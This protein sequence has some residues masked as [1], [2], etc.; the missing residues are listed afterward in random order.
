MELEVSDSNTLGIARKREE[1][2]RS[3]DV[4]SL[5]SQDIK[6]HVVSYFNFIQKIKRL[7]KHIRSE[8]IVLRQRENLSWDIFQNNMLIMMLLTG[9]MLLSSWWGGRVKVDDRSN[10]EL[11]DPL[12]E[13]YLSQ[14][15][16]L[17]FLDGL[18]WGL[19][20]CSLS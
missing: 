8:R 15:K 12:G 2:E 16:I 19:K 14:L 9:L 6:S 17:Y 1:T 3:D 11:E 18:P 13:N 20:L 4:I 10:E 5:L 7:Q